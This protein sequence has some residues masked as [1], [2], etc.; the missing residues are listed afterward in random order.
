MSILDKQKYTPIVSEAGDTV[1]IVAHGDLS[2]SEIRDLLEA[3]TGRR[4]KNKNPVR[5][6]HR[7]VPVPPESPYPGCQKMLYGAE[8]EKPGAFFATTID[9]R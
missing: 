1:G 4:A 3:H 8:E 6:W 2:D 9:L 7:W 5:G